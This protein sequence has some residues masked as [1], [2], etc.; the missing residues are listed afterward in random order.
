MQTMN[1]HSI[2]PSL[3]KEKNEDSKLGK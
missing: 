2:L 3:T 1:F